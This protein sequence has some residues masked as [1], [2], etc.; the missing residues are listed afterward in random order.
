M[1][2]Y[3]N[4]KQILLK[5]NHS[6][7]ASFLS[8]V[9]PTMFWQVLEVIIGQMY[10]FGF[11]KTWGNWSWH[12]C[13]VCLSVLFVKEFHSDFK[14]KSNKNLTKIIVFF[15]LNKSECLDKFIQVLQSGDDFS[16]QNTYQDHLYWSITTYFLLRYNKMNKNSKHANLHIYQSP[17]ALSTWKWHLTSFSMQ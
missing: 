7:E 10:D 8:E 6:K 15:I 13:Y 3:W 16:H 2:F 9:C 11:G 5:F 4:F 14:Q 1:K 17:W 12:L